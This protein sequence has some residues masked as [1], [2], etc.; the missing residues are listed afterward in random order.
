MIRERYLDL[1]LVRRY[2]DFRDA[3]PVSYAPDVEVDVNSSEF[4]DSSTI[5]STSCAVTPLPEILLSCLLVEISAVLIP[6]V[7]VS[8][9]VTFSASIFRTL[10]FVLLSSGKAGRTG[11]TMRFRGPDA[12]VCAPLGGA[13][14]TSGWKRLVKNEHPKV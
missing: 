7:A 8:L 5:G 4:S 13:M 6:F 11:W 10:R 12:W 14:W 2:S 9:R 3:L 1:S